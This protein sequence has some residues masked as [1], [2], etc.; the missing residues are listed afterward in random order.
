[1]MK[2]ME[3]ESAGRTNHLGNMTNEMNEEMKSIEKETN[4]EKF[5]SNETH[6]KTKYD[7]KTVKTE[8]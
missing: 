5:D 8:K 2:K 1:M 4:Q 3:T 7:E 6:A